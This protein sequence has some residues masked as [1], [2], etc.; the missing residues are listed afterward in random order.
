MDL[1]LFSWFYRERCWIEVCRLCA[2]VKGGLRQKK[3]SV[4]LSDKLYRQ[5]MFFL[6]FTNERVVLVYRKLFSRSN[7]PGSSPGRGRHV[8][9]LGK[10]FYFHSASP[11]PGVG[12]TLGVALRWTKF[13]RWG[14]GWDS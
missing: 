10:T 12:G 5:Q 2:L 13:P 3:L 11:H 1:M 9:V 14:G 4:C 8:V 7:C 6:S